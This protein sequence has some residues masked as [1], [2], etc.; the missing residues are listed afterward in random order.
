MQSQVRDSSQEA[1]AVPDH[2]CSGSRGASVWWRYRIPMHTSYAGQQ[3]L[4]RIEKKVTVPGAD[5][6]YA[7]YMTDA[8]LGS[9]YEGIR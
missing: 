4:S 5:I 6:C 9:R 1:A 3:Y 2:A 8:A 7:M